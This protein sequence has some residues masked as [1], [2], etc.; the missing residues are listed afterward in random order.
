M[1]LLAPQSG[2]R[3]RIQL[4]E[5]VLEL[6]DRA[7]GKMEEVVAQVRLNAIK[8]AACK[9]NVKSRLAKNSMV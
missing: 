1:L 6:R 3:T 4:Q 9:V 7:I 2:K 5:K 8:L